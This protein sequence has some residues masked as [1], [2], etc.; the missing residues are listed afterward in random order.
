MPAPQVRLLRKEEEEAPGAPGARADQE[1][2][3]Q[4]EED[5]QLEEAVAVACHRD[6]CLDVHTQIRAHRY[7]GGWPKNIRLF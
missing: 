6:L 4:S 2:A 1:E 5:R 7:L 3:G